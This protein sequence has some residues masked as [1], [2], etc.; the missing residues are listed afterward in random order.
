[1][2]G[3]FFNSVLMSGSIVMVLV[4]FIIMCVNV[5]SSINIYTCYGKMYI[6]ITRFCPDK[7]QVAE[8]TR[9]KL[10]GAPPTPKPFIRFEPVDALELKPKNKVSIFFARF[11]DS[12]D[13]SLFTEKINQYF[14]CDTMGPILFFSPFTYLFVLPDRK[15]WGDVL[16]L[17][18]K[19]WG[20]L[21]E[22]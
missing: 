8:K 10:T 3:L 20:E 17:F 1:M 19:A 15:R 16:P 13:R 5:I 18:Y 7:Y 6:M 22:S 2:C 21:V 14:I 9:E 4:T 12:I 11:E